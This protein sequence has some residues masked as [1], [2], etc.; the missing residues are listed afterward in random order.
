M[1]SI[2][3]DGA[4]LIQRAAGKTEELGH[5]KL[6][7]ISNEYVL[8]VK[9]SR[10]VFGVGD[11]YVRGDSFAALQDAKRKAA[12]STS[13]RLFHHMWLVGLRDHGAA[14]EGELALSI[15]NAESA[16]PLTESTFKDEMEK[17]A[18]RERR[19]LFI[20]TAI[21]IAGLLIGL[22]SII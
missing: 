11:G 17:S 4:N 14:V 1:S 2:V 9:D 5:V 12:Q 10:H 19:N 21:G 6:D 3:W 16:L 20:G 8:W 13:A 15:A 22:A 18:K 7:P